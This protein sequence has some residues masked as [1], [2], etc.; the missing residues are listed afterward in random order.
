M[1]VHPTIRLLH[2]VGAAT[3]FGGSLMG[4]TGLNGATA[5]LDDPA[6][7]ARA[8]TAG[9][10]RWTPVNAAGM[11]AHVVGAAG[12]TITDAPRVAGQHG[13]ARSSAVKAG[14]T[15]AGLG[16]GAWSVA[17]NRKMAAAGPVPVESPTEPGA[18]TPPDVSGV[19]R[20]LK[21]VQWLNPLLAGAVIA[22]ASWQ[23][24]QQ[25][26]S[27]L[28]PGVLKRLPGSL[29]APVLVPAVLAAGAALF[30]AARR[31]RPSPVDAYPVEAYPVAPVVQHPAPGGGVTDLSTLDEPAG[32][33]PPTDR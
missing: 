24:E 23:S 6:E 10:S 3:W 32:V 12:L 11:L 30:A 33:E 5:L 7:R 29:P 17:L 28:A 1:T 26:A 2:D 21:A 27:Q 18:A 9:W 15:A 13:V 4:A 22:T 31:R 20:Q 25:R 8:S 16:V 19:Q 14:L